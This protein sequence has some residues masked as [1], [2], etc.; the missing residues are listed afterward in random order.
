MIAKLTMTNGMVCF[1]RANSVTAVHGAD[2][3]EGGDTIVH[4]DGTM[5]RVKES[6]EEVVA[7]LAKTSGLQRWVYPQ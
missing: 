1:V 4:L 7:E 5:V 2:T 6:T 3:K